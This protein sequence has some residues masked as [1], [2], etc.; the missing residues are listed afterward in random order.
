MSTSSPKP[1]ASAEGAFQKFNVLSVAFIHAVHDIYTAFLA[2]L[3][4]LLKEKLSI[5]YS[6]LGL[7]AVMQRI[8]TV[9]NLFIGILAEKF[10]IRYVLIAA[11]ATTAVCMS[12]IG[13]ASSVW[14]L[15]LLLLLSGI[16]SMFFHIP[17]SVLVKKLSG[18]RVGLGMSMYMIGGELAR[19]VGPM[20]VLWAVATYGL[21]GIWRLMFFGLGTSVFMYFRFRKIEVGSKIEKKSVRFGEYWTTFKA[22]LPILVAI[23]SFNFTRA[24][25]KSSFTTYLPSYINEIENNLF[26]GG[27][28]LTILQVSGVA[29]ISI[30]GPL[31]DKIGRKKTLVALSMAAPLVSLA[32]I[33]STGVASYVFIVLLGVCIFSSS[34]IIL[35]VVHDI[36]TDHL[37]F[38]N[39]IYMM[40]NFLFGA[41]MIW[42]TGVLADFFGFKITYLVASTLALVA[43]PFVFRIFKFSDAR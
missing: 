20:A 28:A 27:L 34:P 25:L 35:A 10:P 30:A 12:F 26:L 2:P 17:G 24:A 40:I 22:H 19:S 38:I 32:Y 9:L 41:L 21:E 43:V 14:S 4:P 8:P 29:G 6:W 7:L 13:V 3:L 5:S 36:K 16:S 15:A 1:S 31:S 33:F 11:P 18:N 37:S 42:F 39:G 23:G